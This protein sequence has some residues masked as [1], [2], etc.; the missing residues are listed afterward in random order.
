MINNTIYMLR[1]LILY[2]FLFC[3][4]C[5]V[6]FSQQTKPAIQNTITWNRALLNTAKKET[7]MT[8]GEKQMIEEIN[9]VRS[10]PKKYADEFIQPLLKGAKELVKEYGSG[11]K[12]F[13]VA[14]TTRGSVVTRD[15][16]WTYKHLE[17]LKAVES[18]ITLLNKLQPLS[19]L[20]PDKG[21]YKAAT[22]H[23]IDQKK[24]GR[25]TGDVK[26]VGSD[27]SHPWDRIMKHSP[28]MGD[29]NEN[30]VC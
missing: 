14:T 30:L 24:V 12:Q 22:L 18:L 15:T 2:S 16:I 26:H 27:N 6:S 9:M 19:I 4:T 1:I 3:L 13:C 11:E 23:A 21:I 10:N 8:E 5:G 25:S 20:K 7:Y 29:G 28:L 17:H